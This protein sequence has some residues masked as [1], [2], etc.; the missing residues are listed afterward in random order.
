MSGNLTAPQVNGNLNGN[1]TKSDPQLCAATENNNINIVNNANSAITTNAP[2]SIAS[3][4]KAIRFRWYNTYWQIGNIRGSSSGTNGFG[5]TYSNNNLCFRVT[6]SG[7]YSYYNMYAPHFYE[8][9]DINL[10][11]NIQE[12]LNS[13]KMPSIKEFDWKE[14][15]SHS[16]GLIAQELEEQGYSE[17]VNTKDDGYKTVNYSAA[18]SLI[19]G[20]LQV[21][22]KELEKEIEMLKN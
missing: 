4:T 20:K 11:I 19:V 7:T 5:I 13:D 17:L 8:N 12:I 10:K 2:T 14:D 3:I 21:K 6:T 16:Y 9:S 15:G 22:I 18:L 1:I